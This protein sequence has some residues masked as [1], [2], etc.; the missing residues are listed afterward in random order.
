MKNLIN[1]TIAIFGI[2]LSLL[3]FLIVFFIMIEG[4]RLRTPLKEGVSNLAGVAQQVLQRIKGGTVRLRAPVDQALGALDRLD[5]TVRERGG[6]NEA[7]EPPMSQILVTLID[8]FSH[9]IEAADQIASS[10]G[11]DAVV[12][13]KSLE[14][15]NRFSRVEAPTLTEE[16]TSL[17]DRLRE[18]EAR[19]QEFREPVD[20]LKAGVV[21]TG[22]KDVLARTQTFRKVLGRM[23]KALEKTQDLLAVKRKALIK[24]EENLL[25]KIDLGTIA[26]SLLCPLLMAGQ[27]SLLFASWR[28]FRRLAY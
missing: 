4:W 12:L 1:K 27:V 10:V 15:I 20:G 24:M 2:G 18:L 21:Q 3:T 19:L 16:L 25:F 22:I 6:R 23:Q 28:M 14:T 13:N 17:S 5:S 9:E 11:E 7:K 26:L 8:R